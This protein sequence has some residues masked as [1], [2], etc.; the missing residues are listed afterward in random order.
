MELT[1]LTD[2]SFGEIESTVELSGE[3]PNFF[4]HKRA[5][6]TNKFIDY[7]SFTRRGSINPTRVELDTFHPFEDAQ[8]LIYY[9]NNAHRSST[10]SEYLEEGDLR[11]S[12]NLIYYIVGNEGIRGLE[13]SGVYDSHY[14]RFDG[15]N[16]TLYYFIVESGINQILLYSDALNRNIIGSITFTSDEAR[17]RRQISIILSPRGYIQLVPS[18][19]YNLSNNIPVL[20]R[21]LIDDSDESNL[22]NKALSSQGYKTRLGRHN[23]RFRGLGTESFLVDSKNNRLSTVSSENEDIGTITGTIFGRA[24]VRIN[25]DSLKSAGIVDERDF[26]SFR[27]NLL[28]RED[29]IIPLGV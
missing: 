19:I 26:N 7:E 16:F 1:F 3:D 17:L 20:N 24:G 9:D 18:N 22:F 21:D 6:I 14:Q 23:T 27:D 29:R 8:E 12:T 2:V 5:L 11:N 10:S 4:R 25:V 15:D 28:I 13:P